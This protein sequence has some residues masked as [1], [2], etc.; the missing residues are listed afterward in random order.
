MHSAKKP[1][2][3]PSTPRGT[4]RAAT[5]EELGG[6]LDEL[7][8][9][10][11]QFVLEGEHFKLLVDFLEKLIIDTQGNKEVQEYIFNMRDLFLTQSKPVKER[12]KRDGRIIV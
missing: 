8:E 7:V 3:P 11:C 2:L 5:A 6:N 1:G 4:A 12:G 10:G 9:M